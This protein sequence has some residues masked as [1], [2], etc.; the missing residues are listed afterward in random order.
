MV[1]V[2]HPR[3]A[4]RLLRRACRSVSCV[5]ASRCLAVGDY[6]TSSVYAVS[7][8]GSGWH[9]VSMTTTGGHIGAFYAVDCMAATSCVALA[10]HHPVRRQRAVGVRVLERHPLEG[11]PHRLT[12]RPPTAAGPA[13]RE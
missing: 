1:R 12:R 7:W 8:N 2:H 4:R 11:G 3:P 10:G 13:G 9:L 5:S 6:G